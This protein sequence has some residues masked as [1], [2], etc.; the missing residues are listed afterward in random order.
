MLTAIKAK[1]SSWGHHS[2][3]VCYLPELFL[4]GKRLVVTMQ[5]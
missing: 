2:C 1:E 3:H 4:I 5:L